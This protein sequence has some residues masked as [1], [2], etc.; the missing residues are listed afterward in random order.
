MWFL[1]FN[2][3]AAL[4]LSGTGSIAQVKGA[5]QLVL[6]SAYYGM[7]C[8]ICTVMLS[9][10]YEVTNVNT[11]THM[12]LLA[13]SL[14]QFSSTPFMGKFQP[15]QPVSIRK[16]LVYI[17]LK[18]AR[19]HT[20]THEAQSCLGPPLLCSIHTLSSGVCSTFILLYTP[21]K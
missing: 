6:T 9:S 3:F 2:C 8:G 20:H 7:C 15:F 11:A 17:S 18:V 19:A 10:P 16:G 21:E 12:L 14:Q 5:Q 4:W 1:G 13:Y